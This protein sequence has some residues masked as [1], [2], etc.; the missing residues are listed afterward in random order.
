[1]NG[2]CRASL[3]LFFGW[4]M[5]HLKNQIKNVKYHIVIRILGFKLCGV[6]S[7][8]SRRKIGHMEKQK[9]VEYLRHQ[10]T[11]FHQ[12]FTLTIVH[13]AGILIPVTDD[14][15]DVG[16]S[17]NLQKISHFEARIYLKKLP[18]SNLHSKFFIAR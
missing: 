8:F 5:C 2:G 16:H 17:Q 12:I 1:M 14:H 3:S 13:R 18:T 7:P 9:N 15:E 6:K 4:K 11:D 10:S